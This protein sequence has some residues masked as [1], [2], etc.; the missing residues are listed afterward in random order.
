MVSFGFVFGQFTVGYLELELFRWQESL[1][2]P[3]LE[4]VRQ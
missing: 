3:I 4:S 2:I 1:A